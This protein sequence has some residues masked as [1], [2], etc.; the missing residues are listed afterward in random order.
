MSSSSSRHEARLRAA[1]FLYQEDIN[2]A[3]NR[4]EAIHMFWDQH[5]APD[6]TRHFAEVLINAV[7]KNLSELD[8]KLA[9]YAQN[10]DIKRMHAVDRNIL[11]LA[12]YEIIYR[13]DIPPVVA[14]NE[15]LDITKEL[16]S[17][18]SAKFVNGILDRALKDVDRP[19]RSPSNQS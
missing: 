19:L 3:E 4:N 2:P 1:Q 6:T 5:E 8:E 16:S 13:P 12:I 7:L 10:W 18:E 11:R 9:S 14:V 15:A 17:D